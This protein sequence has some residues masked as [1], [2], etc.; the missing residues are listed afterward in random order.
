MFIDK[1]LYDEFSKSGVPTA[2][3]LMVTAVGTLGK[4]YIVKEGEIFYY[5]D[6]SV[7]CFNNRF[8]MDEKFLKYYIESPAFIE[9]YANESQGTTVATLT[10]VRVNEYLIP[11]PPLAEQHR[12]VEKLEQLLGKIDKLKK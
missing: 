10:M 1:S 6:G 8:N 9:Q 11:L 7:L 3:D 12:I 4:T 2:G 5:K